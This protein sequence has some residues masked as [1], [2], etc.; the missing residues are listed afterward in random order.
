MSPE[1]QGIILFFLLILSAFFSAAE[2]AL[3]SISE[4]RVFHLLRRAGSSPKARALEHLLRDPGEFITCLVVY[5]NLVNV[6]ASSLATL[7]FL[8]LLPPSLPPY[9]TGLLATVVLTV[10]LL[11]IGEITPKNLARNRAEAVALAVVVPVWRLTRLSRPV[12][13]FF[14]G[15][16]AHLVQPFGVEFFRRERTPLSKDQLVSILELGE[17]RGALSKEHGLMMRR[18]LALDEITAEEVM[19][20]RTEVK[21]IDVATP[22]P[23]AVAF[24]V[25]DGHSRYPVYEGSPDNVIG[26]LH[27]KDLLPH[28]AACRTDLG[29][30][31]LLRPVSY[32]PTT[33]PIGALLREFQQERSHMA[34]V[35]DEYG[36]VAGIVTLEDILEEIVGE[37]ED[38]YDRRRPRP[39]IRRLS[40]TEAIVDGDAEV[41]TV[42]R[43][44]GLDLPES[45]AVTMA[46]LV[47]EKLGDIPEPGTTLR[48]GRAEI[49]VERASAREIHALRLTLLPEARGEGPSEPK[50]NR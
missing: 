2:T 26:I 44:L 4:L 39:L 19:V 31:G 16:A 21:A 33:K 6:A 23:E 34:V 5:N 28:L 14:R 41:R 25:S 1:S 7:L 9:V 22:L 18:I 12:V 36:G 30:T 45:E 17:E 3:S 27:A 46:G 29:L 13:R 43:T 40:P 50:E 48:V 11:L 42:N 10:F 49:A 32:V 35:V 15:A 8:R 47:L 37:I 20:P 24:I 38:E